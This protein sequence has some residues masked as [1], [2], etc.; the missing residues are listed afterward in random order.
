MS[1]EQEKENKEFESLLAEKRYKELFNVLKTIGTSLDKDKDG[2][3][4]KA[5]ANQGVNTEKLIEAVKNALYQDKP[6][7]SNQAE[8]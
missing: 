6:S 3:I 2:A 5:I 1:I 7:S 8:T 4:L